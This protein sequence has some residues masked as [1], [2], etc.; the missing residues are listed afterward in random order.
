MALEAVVFDWGGTLTAGST[1]VTLDLEDVWRASARRL[2]PD[3]V[4]ELTAALFAAER[5]FWERTTTTLESGTLADLLL[6]ASQEVGLDVTDALL[7][8]AA[9]HHLDA[10]TPHI[11]HDPDAA[12]VLTELRERGLRTALLSNTHWP[13]AFHEHFLERDG[14]AALLDAR[15]Y[16]SELHHMKPHPSAFIAALDAVGVSDP[17]NAVFVGDRPYDD[18]SGAKAV[19][20]HTVLRANPYV[21]AFDVEPDAVIDGLLDLLAAIDRF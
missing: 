6:A 12:A 15:L 5:H 18:I 16:S 19:G 3:R 4:E 11:E 8:E 14:L 10:W 21:P 17:A 9:T 7:E 13:R 20:M 2:D 1:I